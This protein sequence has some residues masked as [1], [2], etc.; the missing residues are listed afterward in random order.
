MC[1][2]TR[3]ER[4][5]V[6]DKDEHTNKPPCGPLT[7]PTGL[8]RAL[9]RPA[10]V[11]STIA[12]SAAPSLELADPIAF[13]TIVV[14]CVVVVVVVAVVVVVVVVADA[15]EADVMLLLLL[16]PLSLLL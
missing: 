4:R 6:R 16:M 10:V 15:A 11:A 14:V 9:P 2:G 5:S 13:R 7:C 8:I 3:R 1:K 12:V